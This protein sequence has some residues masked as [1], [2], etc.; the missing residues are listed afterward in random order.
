MTLPPDPWP[1]PD[2]ANRDNPDA[3]NHGVSAEEPAEGADDDPAPQP[4][5]PE[6]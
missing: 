2:E 5:S 6:G 4:G 1:E 3:L